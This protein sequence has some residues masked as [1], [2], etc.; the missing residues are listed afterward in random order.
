MAL[1]MTYVKGGLPVP[2][3]GESPGLLLLGTAGTLNGQL[4]G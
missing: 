4:A 2:R 3:M 1:A